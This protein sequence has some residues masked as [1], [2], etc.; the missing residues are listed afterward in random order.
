MNLNNRIALVTGGATRVG[1]VLCLE[2]AV[3]GCAVVVH[4][5][6]SR[7]AA[8]ALVN[9][10]QRRG[11]RAAALQA[12]LTEPAECRRLIGAAKRA[13]GRPDILI[14]NAA[15]FHRRDLRHTSAADLRAAFDL[16]L[17]A[18]VLLMRYFAAQTDAG[19]IV[20]VLDQRIVSNRFDT[21][22]YSLSK[23]SLAAATAAAA[24]ELAPKCTVNAVA[25]GPVLLPRRPAAREPAGSIPLKRR[26]TPSDVAA[27]VLFLLKS[28]AVTGQV[29][30]TDGGMHLLG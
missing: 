28:D 30:F 27:A 4:Y 23:K 25:P 11:G 20:N 22:A 6:R 19:R 10:L 17:I 14:N 21:F 29:I 5:H 24:L 13:L 15:V 7:R 9:T 3:A 8:E 16:N 26:P 18:P 1:R 12:D 2:L